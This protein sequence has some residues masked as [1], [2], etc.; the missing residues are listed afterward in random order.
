MERQEYGRSC[1]LYC[2]DT[3]SCLAVSIMYSTGGDKCYF[4]NTTDLIFIKHASKL[5]RPGFY[6]ALIRAPLT[7]ILSNGFILHYSAR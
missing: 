7:T 1:F 2:Q 4:Y 3:P 5:D 6:N